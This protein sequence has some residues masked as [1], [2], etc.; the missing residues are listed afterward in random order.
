MAVNNNVVSVTAGLQC[1][2][3]SSPAIGSA[4]VSAQMGYTDGHLAEDVYVTVSDTSPPATALHT[5]LAADGFVFVANP[6][7]IGGTTNAITVT[8][9]VGTTI[10]GPLPPGFACVVP[11]STGQIVGGVVASTAVAVGVTAIRTTANA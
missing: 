2:A 4:S 5:D 7:T 8:L 10:L 9:Y 3:L 1:T 11:V 6:A